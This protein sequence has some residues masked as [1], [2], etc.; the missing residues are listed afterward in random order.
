MPAILPSVRIAIRTLARRPAITAVAVLS[1]AVGIG[2]N[3]AIFSVVDTL[4]FR[5]PPVRDPH[6]LIDIAGQFRDSGFTVLSWPDVEA[7]RTQTAA[8]SEVTAFQDRGAL[9]R[10]GDERTDLLAKVVADNFFTMLDVRPQLGRFPD[11]GRDYSADSEPPVVISNGFWRNRLGGRSDII[12]Q[13]LVLTYRHFRV[14]AVLPPGFQGFSLD[15][16]DYEIWFPVGSWTKAMGEPLTRGAGQYEVIARLQPGVTIQQ[17]QAQLDALAKHIEESDSR[18]PKGRRLAALSAD[19][20]I[21]GRAKTGALV[22]GTVAL[23]LLTACANVAGVML[24]FAESRR[25]E[26]GIRLAVGASRVALTK[27]LLVESVVLAAA[28]LGCGLLLADWIL[29]AAPALAPPSPYP[30]LVDLRLDG[31]MFGFAIASTLATVVVFGIAPLAHVLRTSVSEALL[32]ARAVGPTR[33][34]TRAA[35]VCAQLAMSVFL[36]AGAACLARTLF[37][38]RGIYAGFDPHKRMAI[39]SA[40]VQK[41]GAES[42]VFAKAAQ[43]IESLP[44]VEAV[45]YARHLPLWGSGSGASLEATPIASP[46]GATQVYFDLV[47]PRYFETVG[48]RLSRGRTFTDSDHRSAAAVAILNET[49]ARR[50]WPAQDALGKTL[51]IGGAVY[52]VVGVAADGRVSDLHED[53]KSA[54][55]L[56]ASR[57]EWGETMFLITARSDPGPLMKGISRAVTQTGE[58]DIEESGTLDALMTGE[59][60]KDWAPTV[61]GVALAAIGVLLAAGGLYGAIAFATERRFSEFG[62]RIAMGASRSHVRWIVVR[63][64]L[65]LC[66]V[67]S[68]LGALAFRVAWRYLAPLL[69]RGRGF[70]FVP[71]GIGIAVAAAIAVTGALLPASRA[72][73]VDPVAALRAE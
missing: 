28:G 70:D 51:R 47:G 61:L 10:N 25:R 26:I 39:I 72:A 67:G 4:L 48:A 38:S 15:P 41:R 11:A 5:E 24:V 8:F 45:T 12:G 44:G 33:S 63:R 40:A 53:A 71:V 29:S 50:F 32:T 64:A 55:F 21:R 35:F 23:V 60:W 16:Y 68:P 13:P 56:P 46:M 54:V 59:L 20:K 34:F 3:S 1:L 65:L 42:E 9:Y 52:E 30:L 7:I 36:V 6:S 14:A 31:R 17:A 73:R 18:V 69:A 19:E 27:Q 62:I 57:M 37:D 43:R 66:A 22:L 58:M 2:V 49:A